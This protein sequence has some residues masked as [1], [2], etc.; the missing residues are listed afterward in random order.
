MK[1]L[2]RKAH[3]MA[4]EIKAEYPEVNYK[5]QLGLCMSYLLNNKEGN[6]DRANELVKE[7]N[8]TEEEAKEL[9]IVEKHYQ[10]EYAENGKVNFNIWEGYGK[11]RAYVN[12]SWRSRSANAKKNYYDF[13]TKYLQDRYVAKQF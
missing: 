12:L 2:M 6:M 1:E 10:E 8:I 3:K 9:V 13:T 5:T 4:K 7:L 11:K